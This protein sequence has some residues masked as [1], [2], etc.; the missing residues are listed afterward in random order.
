MKKV[1]VF[2]DRNLQECQFTETGKTTDKGNEHLVCTSGKPG[3]RDEH[4]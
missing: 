3:E 4:H 1:I 2:M